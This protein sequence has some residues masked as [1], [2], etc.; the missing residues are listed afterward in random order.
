VVLVRRPEHDAVVG[1]RGLLI[2]V[3]ASLIITQSDQWDEWIAAAPDV[4]ALLLLVGAPIAGVLGG[5]SAALLTGLLQGF[6]FL[7]RTVSSTPNEGIRWAGWNVLF[8]WVTAEVAGLITYALVTILF[9]DMP[10]DIRLVLLAGLHTGLLVEWAILDAL[11]IGSAYVQHY[12]LRALL[13]RCGYGP[14]RYVRFLDYATSRHLLR[15]VGGAYEFI[16]PL[17]REHFVHLRFDV[18]H[19][20]TGAR[21]L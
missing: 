21:P 2:G 20:S 10:A 11:H 8:F 6:S 12:L 3:L 13:V 14:W 1:L 4:T 9:P 7:R 17:L 15:R 19:S 18:P 5:L 16:H